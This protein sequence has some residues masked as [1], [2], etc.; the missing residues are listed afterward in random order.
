M[1]ATISRIRVPMPAKIEMQRSATI[2]IASDIA[3]PRRPRGSPPHNLGVV[4]MRCDAGPECLVVAPAVGS[5]A[6]STCRW[7]NMEP[8]A[9]YQ[10]AGVVLQI[11]TLFFIDCATTDRADII[12]WHRRIGCLNRCRSEPCNRGKDRALQLPVQ[13]VVTLLS[14]GCAS[15]AS[16]Y[17]F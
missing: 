14:V 11:D 8:L 9:R 15:R 3:K 1:T 5:D 4:P 13:R 10:I 17:L 7:R 2:K 12:R 6:F 16:F